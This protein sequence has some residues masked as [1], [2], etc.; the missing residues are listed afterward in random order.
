[1]NPLADNL[2]R[3]RVQRGW[4]QAELAAKIGA[5]QTTICRIESGTSR[6]LA[7]V[8][9]LAEAL[10]VSTSALL[11]ELDKDREQHCDDDWPRVTLARNLLRLR[12]ARGWSQ[13]QLAAESHGEVTR[14]QVAELEAGVADPRL[15]TLTYIAAVLG[16]D[17]HEL[18]ARR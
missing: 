4:S 6:S 14:L 13:S 17:F 8:Q 18:L 10:E 7:T 1:M 15:S 11:G 12:R 3:L 5:Q 16:C 9:R 2:A